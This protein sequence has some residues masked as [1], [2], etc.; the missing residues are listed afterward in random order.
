[1]PIASPLTVGVKFR[2][3]VAAY[4]K[5]IRFYKGI[6]N[7]GTHVGMLYTSTGTLLAQATFTSET[8]SGWQEVDFPSPV[9]IA[10]N[11][12]YVAAY[13]TTIGCAYD[14]GYFTTKGADNAPLHALQSGVDGQNGVYVYAAS[15]QFPANS[16]GDANYWVDVVLQ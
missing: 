8:A 1:M 12:T 6:G 3:D 4:V 11:T 13:F 15:P 9:P 5:G 16:Y 7:S 2:S 10:A 14:S